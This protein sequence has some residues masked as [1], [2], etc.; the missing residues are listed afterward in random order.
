[1]NVPAWKI[2]IAALVIGIVGDVLLRGGEFRLGFALWIAGVCVSVV[3]VGG[4]PG[5]ERVLLLA[6]AVLAAFGL[7][8][9]DAPMLVTIDI[10][11]VLC[12]GALT[13][14]HGT[15]RRIGELTVVESVRAGMLAVVNTLGGA[16]DVLQRVRRDES[17]GDVAGPGRS[18]AIL[19]GTVLALPPVIVVTALLA[20]SDS[21]FERMLQRAIAIDGLGHVLLVLVL[22]W[23]A[24]G[25][26]RSA[27]GDPLAKSLL[28][29][30]SPG[31]PFVSIAVGLYAL[32]ALLTLFV[33]TQLRVLF[34]GAEFLRV[35]EGLTVA[36]YAREGFFQLILASAVVLGT[37]LAAEWLLAGDDTAGRRR[38]SV[39]G[40]ILV[41][42]V[43]ALLVSSATRIWLYV[44]EFG[45]SV[46]RS[47][48]VAGILGVLAVV[49]VLVSTTL[50]GRSD[51]FAPVTL[52]CT[53]GWVVM[54]NLV[55]LEA[56]VV[57]VNMSRASQGLPFDAKYHAQLSA[58]ALPALLQGAPLLS[59][60]DCERLGVELREAWRLRLIGDAR[61][62]RGWNLPR[63]GLAER[64]RQPVA[65]GGAMP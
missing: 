11:S 63:R 4:R 43:L 35:A 46:D 56:R 34:G 21:V 45:L 23:M 10:L 26:L 52:L 59:A 20:S 44:S 58:D 27:L 51:Q 65:C 50:R 49:I 61:D 5:A 29:V 2:L 47:Y 8:W 31:L 25:W 9:N 41:T 54:L 3:A 42:L 33:A 40:G 18:R 30:R 53:I 19:L 38:Y 62:W 7:V 39:A 36:N 60:A 24:T 13:I 64:L 6:G 48:A 32:I 17:G 16:A 28:R 55:N 12:M 15:G 37:L 57:T 14:W 22:A 1:M